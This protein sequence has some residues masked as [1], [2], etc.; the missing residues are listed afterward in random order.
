MKLNSTKIKKI[1]KKLS[2]LASNYDMKMKVVKLNKKI[3]CLKVIKSQYY[4]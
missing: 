4:N 1:W 2:M 3:V